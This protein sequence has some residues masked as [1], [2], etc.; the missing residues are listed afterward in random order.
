VTSVSNGLSKEVVESL[1]F[2]QGDVVAHPE[3]LARLVLEG[4]RLLAIFQ[5]SKLAS[6]LKTSKR[7]FHEMPYLLLDADVS[8]T[9]RPDLL[10]EDEFGNWTIVDYKTDK[11]P[12]E[13]LAQQ[14]AK[15]HE[16]LQEYAR[17][18][19]RLTGI[20]CSTYIYFAEF[21]TLFDSTKKSVV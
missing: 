17:D 9:K 19:T 10:I 15:H 21:G 6:I 11:F 20:Q 7:H 13:K 3:A 18:L 8:S 16:Q 2:A 1:A 4:E 12:Q 14:A 5:N